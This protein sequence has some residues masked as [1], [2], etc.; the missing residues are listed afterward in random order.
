MGRKVQEVEG[1]VTYQWAYLERVGR[2]EQAGREST[3]Q[4][5]KLLKKKIERK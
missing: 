4:E 3:K 5:Y 1:R 2:N